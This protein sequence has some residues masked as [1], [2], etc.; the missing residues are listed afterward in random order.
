MGKNSKPALAHYTF[1]PWIGCAKRCRKT[2]NATWQK[3][4][5]LNAEAERYGVSPRVFC[6]S[7][8]DV[9]DNAA[10]ADWRLE[11]FDL[12]Q[13]TPY[14]DWLLLTR[15]IGNAQKMLDEIGCNWIADKTWIGITVCNQEEAD[16]DIPKF[17]EVPVGK[18]FLSIEPLLGKIHLT[19][20]YRESGLRLI[21]A[22]PG[23]SLVI[24][25]GETGYRNRPINPDWVRA[26]RDQ[27]VAAHVP[28]LFGSLTNGV[29]TS[30][31]RCGS[32]SDGRK[33]M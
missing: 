4:L 30:S 28:F 18:R 26:L 20:L 9:F 31:R 27:C 21:G 14:L 2:S 22:K 17:L 13:K 5:K 33:T 1:N 29:R 10:N 23:I 8:C 25:S 19:C 11:L 3:P 12:I 32:H 7:R 6:G 15:R 16:R 24:C